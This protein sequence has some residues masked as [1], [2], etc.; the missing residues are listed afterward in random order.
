MPLLTADPNSHLLG[1]GADESPAGCL[2]YRD[3]NRSTTRVI[4]G[5]LWYWSTRTALIWSLLTAQRLRGNEKLELGRSTTRRGGSSSCCAIAAMGWSEIISIPNPSLLWMTLTERM[6]AMAPGEGG[7]R[8]DCATPG[9]ATRTAEN[10]DS[11]RSW[12]PMRGKDFIPENRFTHGTIPLVGKREK[13]RGERVLSY[14][15]N[16]EG[17]EVAQRLNPKGFPSWSFVPFV[18][19]SGHYRNVI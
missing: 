2:H 7:A 10:S 14:F 6:T 4:G 12:V 18:V 1:V 3:G 8:S 16:H 17:H 19:K 15:T 13:W 11:P 9:L 5:V